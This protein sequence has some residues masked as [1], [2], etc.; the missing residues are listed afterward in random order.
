MTH[1]EQKVQNLQSDNRT[2]EFRTKYSEL[3]LCWVIFPE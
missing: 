3:F 1:S 2:F